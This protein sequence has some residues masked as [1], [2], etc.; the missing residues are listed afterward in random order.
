MAAAG[1]AQAFPQHANFDRKR[2]GV[3]AA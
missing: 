1:I 2:C 3:L